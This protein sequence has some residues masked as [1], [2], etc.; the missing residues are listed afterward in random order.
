MDSNSGLLLTDRQ[1]VKATRAMLLEDS[2]S[3]ITIRHIKSSLY[4]DVILLMPAGW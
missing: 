3:R 1:S 4:S 2:A